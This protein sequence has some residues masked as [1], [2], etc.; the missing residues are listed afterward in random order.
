[1]KLGV[2]GLMAF[3]VWSPVWAQTAQTTVL[4]GEEDL[5]GA[6]IRTQG[7]V[8]IRPGT[9]IRVGDGTCLIIRAQEILLEGDVFVDGRGVNGRNG[10]NGAHLGDW[11]S[12]GDGDF[13]Q[14]LDECR[15]NPDHKDRGKN[16]A[17]G[18]EGGPGAIIVL[19]PEPTGPGKI[20]VRV[21]GGAG[22]A[23]GRGGPGRLLRNGRQNY[24]DGCMM[25]CPPGQDGHPGR[26]GKTGRYV[27]NVSQLTPEEKH[28][29]GL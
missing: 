23:G 3:L 26:R 16:G 22:G 21:N 27:T 8:V 28:R 19:S 18:E 14:A 20:D 10:S 9:R 11:S 12:K 7:R 25:N 29:C 13:K 4:Q 24:C 2:G 15:S 17:D 6:N 5:T 1:M